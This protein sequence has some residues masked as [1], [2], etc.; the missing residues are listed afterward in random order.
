LL[1]LGKAAAGALVAARTYLTQF[2]MEGHG[3]VAGP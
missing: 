1:T 2:Q 3:E